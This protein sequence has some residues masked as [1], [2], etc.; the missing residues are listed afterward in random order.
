MGRI[1][2]PATAN[3]SSVSGAKL[4]NYIVTPYY[5][6]PCLIKW[7]NLTSVSTSGFNVFDST[8]YGVQS[9]KKSSVTELAIH[10]SRTVD[11]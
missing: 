3:F 8:L 11:F 4:F 6:H 5:D 9:T 10:L 1:V 7:D 2:P